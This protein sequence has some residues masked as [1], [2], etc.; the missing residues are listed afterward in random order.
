MNAPVA[1]ID[2]ETRSAISLKKHGAWRYSIDL[3]TEILCLCWHLPDFLPGRTALWAPAQ[4]HIG[5]AE[6]FPAGEISGLIEW[7]EQGGL[8]S[9]HNAAFER[10]IWTNIA[11]PRH[12]WPP[13]RISQWK[14]SAAKSA[15]HALPRSLDDVGSALNLPIRKDTDGS[16]VMMKMSKPRKSRKAERELWAKTGV[17]PSAILWHESR[18]QLERL[19]AYCRQDVLAEVALNDSLPDLN[20]HES[21]VYTMDQTIN[22]RGFQLD[23]AAV[24]FAL[25]L[26]ATESTAL[27]KELSVLTN[28]KV[29]RATQRAQMMAW[30]ASEGLELPNT[31]KETIDAY[32]SPVCQE[33]F[34]PNA[35]RGLEIMRAL[36]RSSTAK[37]LSMQ[38]WASRDGRV[39]GGLLYHGASTGRWSGSGVQPHNFPR[40]AIK[41]M[42]GLWA[43]LKSETPPPNVMEALS[44]GLRGAIVAGPQKTLYVADYAAIEARVVTWLAGEEEALESFRRGEDIYSVM[45]SEIYDKPCS[46]EDTPDERQVGK[47]AIL[48]LGF[49]MGAPKFVSTVEKMTGIIISEE[50]A[51]Q[52]VDAYRAKFPGVKQLWWDMEAAA[53]TAARRLHKMA[54]WPPVKCGRVSWLVEDE[55]L[56][57]ELPSGRR[58]A[59]PF[60]KVG[61]K[62]TPWGEMR[63]QLTFMGVDPYTR[64]WK[65]QHTYG[66]SLVENVV[67]AIARDI[68]ADAMLRIEDTSQ[69]QVTLTV[70]DEI[71]CESSKGDIKE[72]LSL[73][74]DNPEWAVGLPIAV[75]GFQANR[76]RK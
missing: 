44:N 6:I 54:N 76:Y 46:K 40:G 21:L 16:K 22:Q 36:G 39:R 42:E 27:N 75:E 38:N 11:V 51:K 31:Q 25:N 8:V 1:V 18:E 63:P 45:A 23:I 26:I 5:L 62:A 32:L 2:F 65:R 34:S 72:F 70:H 64:K 12:G 13:I 7:I 59:Y 61:S 57:C 37:Y 43:S 19:W 9:A 33:D 29:Q 30:L 53:I 55:F 47:T 69:Y 24:Q 58:L 56:Y 48:G 74:G 68:M 52:V 49:Q 67:Q 3:T 17:T 66:G 28:G 41:D 4:P 50:M 35:R 20:P 14:C 60:P 10:C 71:V 73:V 15:A